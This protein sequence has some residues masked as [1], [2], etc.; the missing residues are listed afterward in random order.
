MDAMSMERAVV[1]GDVDALRAAFGEDPA[2]PN[3]RDECGQ[4]ALDHAIYR[5]PLSL[6]RA[7]L[8]L[9]AD[10]NYID[11]GGFPSLFAA[12]DRAGPDRHEVLSMLL[13]AGADVEQRGMNDYTALH[14]AACRD[15]A[16]AVELLL[17][18]GA[19]PSA[20]TRIDHW[21]TP[22]EEAEQFGHREGAEALRRHTPARVRDD[23]RA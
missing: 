17:N 23:D 13:A 10:P 18:H 2:F 7:L 22:L 14:H 11:D 1:A 16:R 3:V 12:V 21:A 9:G 4:W 8:S 15:D 6:V 20:R 19:D 5:G